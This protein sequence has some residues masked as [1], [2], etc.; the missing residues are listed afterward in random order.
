[1]QPFIGVYLEN[2]IFSY[3]GFWLHIG[4][5]FYKWAYMCLPFRMPSWEEIPGA[6]REEGTSTL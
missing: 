1:M 5:F 4:I 2:P 3:N 6:Q